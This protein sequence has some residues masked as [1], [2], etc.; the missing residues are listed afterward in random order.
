MIHIPAV[1]K[2]MLPLGY[3]LDLYFDVDTKQIGFKPTLGGR[4]KLGVNR[5]V[6]ARSFLVYH[7]IPLRQGVKAAWSEDHGMLITEPLRMVDSER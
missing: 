3:I 1:F 4:F 2:K 5:V 6:Y 7:G